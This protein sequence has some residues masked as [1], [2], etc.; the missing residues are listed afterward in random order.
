[1]RPRLLIIAGIV[2]MVAGAGTSV[3]AL[4]VV[5]PSHHKIA[6]VSFAVSPTRIELPVSS[7]HLVRVIRV[8][9]TGRKALTLSAVVQ[10]GHQL[11]SGS[12]VF[13]APSP[14]SGAS[15]L[16]ISPATIRLRAGQTRSVKVT[17]FVPAR[18]SPGQRYLGVHFGYEADV[19]LHGSG[20]VVAVGINAQLIIDVSGKI[21]HGVK[22]GPLTAPSFTWHGPIPLK[23]TYKDEGNVLSLNNHL[24]ARSG[25]SEIR[26]PGILVLAGSAR[27]VTSSWDDPP[28]WCLP[29]RISVDGASVTVWR[30]DPVY[31]VAFFLVGLAAAM[32]WDIRRRWNRSMRRAAQSGSHAGP[33]TAG[34]KPG[35]NVTTLPGTDHGPESV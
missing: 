14:D 4:A 21:R 30:L 8:E 2:A 23:L 13:S 27:I 1:M 34:S 19:N 17:A 6:P 18:H 33:Q 22:I 15:W 9:D 12:F 10:Q 3:P 26:F 28:S 20:A 11:S 16:K 5:R 32:L 35:S 29:C 31:L 7:R 24:A 25:S